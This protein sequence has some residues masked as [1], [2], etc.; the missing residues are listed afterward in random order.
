MAGPMSGLEGRGDAF[1]S[2][3]G[4]IACLDDRLPNPAIL[5]RTL[6]LPE[7]SDRADR[8]GDGGVRSGSAMSVGMLD[9]Q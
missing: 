3:V 9:R 6:N 1:G 7:V 8:A 2:V 4:K 5:P